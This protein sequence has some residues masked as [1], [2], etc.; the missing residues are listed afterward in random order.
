[1]G[2]G[3]ARDGLLYFGVKEPRTTPRP[4]T[5]SEK[6]RL[7]AR[8]ESASLLKTVV[9]V[10]DMQNDYSTSS[11]AAAT[12]CAPAWHHQSYAGGCCSAES[13]PHKEGQRLALG[14]RRVLRLSLQVSV[15][16]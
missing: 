3:N 11:E 15:G 14:T 10:V 5:Q 8:M 1:M 9:V 4:A 16:H 2:D 12:R 13:S 7:F 6:D